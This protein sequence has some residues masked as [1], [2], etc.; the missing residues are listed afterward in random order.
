MKIFIMGNIGSGKTT[1]ANTL[2]EFYNINL[3]HIDEIVHDDVNNKKRTEEEQKNIINKILKDNKDWIIEGTPRSNLELL[4]NN[5]E[6]IIFLDID[7]KELIKR[8]KKRYLKRKL[9]IEKINYKIDKKSLK[10][11]INNIE[12]SNYNRIY[13]QL[14]KHIRKGIIIKNE[15]EIKK[16]MD[17]VYETYK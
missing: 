10:E 16:Y 13:E 11:E 6:E 15:T 17:S 8:V 9:K 14:T 4:C 12:K 5:A 2:S 7:K 3:Y 1:L